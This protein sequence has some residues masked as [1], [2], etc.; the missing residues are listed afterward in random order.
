VK[1]NN[2]VEQNEV[3]RENQFMTWEAH[4]GNLAWLVLLIGLPLGFRELYM[5]ELALRD[6]EAGRPEHERV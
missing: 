1:K 2:W 3:F 4:S 6:K 5:A